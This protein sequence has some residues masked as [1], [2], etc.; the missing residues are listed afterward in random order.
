M[1]TR[2]QT[3]AEGVKPTKNTNNFYVIGP[4]NKGLAPL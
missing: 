2:I 3:M 4:F 1:S